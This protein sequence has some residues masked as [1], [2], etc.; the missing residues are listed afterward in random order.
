MW[1]H[2][3]ATPARFRTRPR[4]MNL[5][6]IAAAIAHEDLS[7]KEEA[8]RSSV[9]WISSDEVAVVAGLEGVG[10][11]GLGGGST[12]VSTAVRGARRSKTIGVHGG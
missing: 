7:A 6:E 10:L 8:A 5:I 1:V 9:N 2:V 3:D 11:D 4:R 12:A